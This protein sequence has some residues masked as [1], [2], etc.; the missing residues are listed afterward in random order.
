MLFD[1]IKVRFSEPGFQ[2]LAETSAPATNF[3]PM[4]QMFAK[5]FRKRLIIST[6]N[7]RDA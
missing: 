7:D 1:I 3:A 5:T 6:K 2:G 4:C